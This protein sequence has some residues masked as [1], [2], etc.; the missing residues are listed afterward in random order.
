M[1]D[2][3]TEKAKQE[4]GNC[5][6]HKPLKDSSHSRKANHRRPM[7]FKP[8]Q[9]TKEIEQ[10]ARESAAIWTKIPVKAS[11]LAWLLVAGFGVY[12]KTKVARPNLSY[13]RNPKGVSD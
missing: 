12:F 1:D 7:S 8:K 6:D 11:L 5:H 4:K 2:K 13:L 9:L 10:P 3:E